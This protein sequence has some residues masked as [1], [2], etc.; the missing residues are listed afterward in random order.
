MKIHK[1]DQINSLHRLTACT[2]F[3][4]IY[5]IEHAVFLFIMFVVFYYDEYTPW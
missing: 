5:I 4:I 3:D 1:F 2:D